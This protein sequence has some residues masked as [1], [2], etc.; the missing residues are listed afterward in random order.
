VHETKGADEFAKN[1]LTGGQV[2]LDQDRSLFQAL[3]DRW[4]GW[5]GFF[6]PSVWKNI[7]R[8]KKKGVQG[9]MEGEGRLLGGVIVVGPANQGVL[10]VHLEKVWGDRADT[11]E[12]I[13]ACQKMQLPQK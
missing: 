12:V 9:N 5:R 11:D 6:L 13:K 4:L 10:F 1:Y 8:A 2:Y 3:G 7:I